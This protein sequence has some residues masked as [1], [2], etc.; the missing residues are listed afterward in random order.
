MD[1]K[2]INIR[3]I[4]EPLY[5]KILELKARL[6]ARTWVKFLEMIAKT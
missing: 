6:K 3:N 1:K 4:P 2:T 5:Y